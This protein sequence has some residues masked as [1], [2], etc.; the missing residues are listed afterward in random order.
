[1]RIA[2]TWNM[3]NMNQGYARKF[4][5]FLIFLK[6]FKLKGFW[7]FISFHLNRVYSGFSEKR[8][9][10]VQTH[11]KKT[12]TSGLIWVINRYVLINSS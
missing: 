9:K 12:K 10:C 2:R 6:K 8:T 4:I 3:D 7:L 1:M 5:I 11:E